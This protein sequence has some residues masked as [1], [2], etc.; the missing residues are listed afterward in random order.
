MT[1]TAQTPKAALTR[2]EASRRLGLSPERVRQLGQAGVLPYEQ[3]PLGRLYDAS[4]VDAYAV[5]RQ[6]R[7]EAAQS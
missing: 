6:R 1:S 4:A 5:E 3:T 7:R 2:G